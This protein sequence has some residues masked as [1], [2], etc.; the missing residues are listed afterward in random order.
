[1]I[2]NRPDDVTKITF[3]K[4]ASFNVENM[5]R[6][7]R[8]FNQPD[9][10]LARRY[11]LGAAELNLLFEREIY[12]EADKLRMV[13]LLTELGLSKADRNR[14]A[15]FRSIRGNLF[16]RTSGKPLEII[17][18]GR[19]SWIGWIELEQEPVDAIAIQNTARVIRDVDPDILALM[20]VEDRRALRQ[21]NDHVL[22]QVGGRGYEH[23]MVIEG[24]DERGI[25]VGVM[26]RESY[27]LRLMWSHV[28][29]KSESGFP[30]FSRDAPEYEVRMPDGDRLWV[31]PC[32]FKSKFGGDNASSRKKRALQAGKVAEIYKRLRKEGDRNI[33]VLGDFNDTPES[34]PLRSLLKETDLKDVSQHPSFDTGTY[35]GTGTFGPGTAAHKIDYLL[36]SPDLFKRVT[37]CGLFRKGAW[38]G[39]GSKPRWEVYPELKREEHAAS[40]HHLLWVELT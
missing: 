20:E 3:M 39:G 33:V 32:H 21:F 8:V 36:L 12:D 31:I 27:P 25:D 30:L 22:T 23:I 6:R 13:E 24:N 37:A 17:A 40:D 19:E 35:K 34:A 1:L 28:H 9:A 16:K 5:F 11:S 18:Q 10:D 38:P 4:I 2:R 29:E 26:T 14:Y 15:T 7:T